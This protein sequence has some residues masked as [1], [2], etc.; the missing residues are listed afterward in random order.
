MREL[1]GLNRERGNLKDESGRVVQRIQKALDSMNIKIHHAVT[2]LTGV[3]GMSILRA[4]V[5]G[6]RD[7]NELARLRDRR[8]K[9]SV[10]QISEHLQG[11][12]MGEHL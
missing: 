3:T 12:W 11:T 8:C 6:V 2:D 9:K 4:I 10:E 1:R 7:P 5:A